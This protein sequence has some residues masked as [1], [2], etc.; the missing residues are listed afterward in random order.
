MQEIGRN[1][2]GVLLRAG[3]AG[4]AAHGAAAYVATAGGG[5]IAAAL[6]GAGTST[7]GLLLGPV[8]V[9]VSG[10]VIVN[11]L[12]RA[13]RKETSEPRESCSRPPPRHPGRRQPPQSRRS[14]WLATNSIE[15]RVDARRIKARQ[16]VLKYGSGKERLAKVTAL[17][18]DEQALDDERAGL[19]GELA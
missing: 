4:M 15:R 9:V 13:H 18:H 16:S 19:R 10:M 1:A 7:I 6:A 5:V 11:A 2:V 3:M 12:L 17:L 14:R 8:G